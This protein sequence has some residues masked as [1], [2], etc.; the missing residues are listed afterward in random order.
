MRKNR[1]FMTAATLWLLSIVPAVATD[2]LQKLS[3]DVRQ[4]VIQTNAGHRTAGT[5]DKK[6]CVFIRF[7]GGNAEQLLTEY[8]CEK[9]TQ[10]DDIYIANVPTAQLSAMAACD[11]VNRIETNTSGKLLLDVTP[12]WIDNNMV[13]SGTGL[14][15]GY[16]GKGV[17]LGIVDCGFDFTHPTNYSTDGKT[18]RLKGAVDDY[19]P[20]GETIGTKTVLGM[21]YLTKEQLLKKKYTSDV[22]NNHGT[23]CLGIA[24]GSG[25]GTPYRGIAYG[26]D[27]FAIS[28]MN[29][30]EE[31]IANSADQTARMKHIFDYATQQGMPCVITYSIGFSALPND[32]QL[33]TE[34]LEKL[35]GPGRILVAAAGNSN[36]NFRYVRKEAGT[37]A[38]TSLNLTNGGKAQCYL[39]ADKPFQIK[40]FTANYVN[41]K[42]V[43]TDSLI[44]DTS[45]LP[46]D[47]VVKQNL[48]VFLENRGSYYLLTARD[49]SSSPKCMPFVLMGND[50]AISLNTL[51]PYY[52]SNISTEKRFNDAVRNHNVD[53]PGALEAAVT[54]GALNGR[55]SFTNYKDSVIYSW[56]AHSPEGTIA[57]F[58]SCGPTEDGRMKP[59]VVAPGVNIISAGN[60]YCPDTYSASMVTKTSFNNREYPWV[61]FSGTSMATPCAAG[62][63]ALWLQ[64]DPTLTPQRIKEIIKTT[65]KKIEVDGQWPNNVYGY[66][67]IDA[68]AGII[69]V[70]KGATGIQQISSHQPTALT[71][72]PAQ[73][74]QV[75]LTFSQAPQ[76]A[77]HVTVY[78]LSGAKCYEQT[79]S[80]GGATTYTLQV[81]QVPTGV[82]IVQVDSQEPSLNGSEIIRWN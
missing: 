37:E 25:Y 33:F 63:V 49:D 64:A 16:D 75:C 70:I 73:G 24:A 20:A 2:H 60:S 56:G 82:Y 1:F 15:Q 5:T 14:P 65:S 57:F 28:S 80:T 66:G 19:A 40:C 38:S 7:N 69:E 8:G 55:L 51:T 6:V 9:V 74:R 78:S 11:E 53:I 79:L 44:L 21:E 76:H 61:S 43:I 3:E 45:K 41:S 67:L 47:T 26:A 42:V 71:I 59:D 77:L 23:H 18:Y 72:R 27:I 12:K 17:L 31:S 68:Y 46:A 13:Y 62:I 32:T 34:C 81:P 58:S 35:V 4:L 50:A 48:H 52:L 10:I 54:V 36:A 29:A 39:I 22:H 30:A